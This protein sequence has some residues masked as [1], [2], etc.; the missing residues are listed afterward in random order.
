MPVWMNDLTAGD[1][2]VEVRAAF[3]RSM[4]VFT[5]IPLRSSV[6]DKVC[7]F[8]HCLLFYSHPHVVFILLTLIL[9]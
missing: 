4:S 7:L 2:L 6:F 5:D 9:Y 1:R 8:A 3:G